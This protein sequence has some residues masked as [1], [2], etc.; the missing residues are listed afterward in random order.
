MKAVAGVKS[1]KAE[2]D[3]RTWWEVPEND[4][5]DGRTW[6]VLQ[7]GSPFSPYHYPACFAVRTDGGK[8]NQ[9]MRFGGARPGESQYRKM[10]LAYGKRTDDM[11]AYLLPGGQIFSQEGQ[12]LFPVAHDLLW[13]S[14]QLANSSIYIRH[15]NYVAGQHKYHNYLNL[16]CLPTG[17]LRSLGITAKRLFAE[18]VVLDACN[19]TSLGFVGCSALPEFAL[20]QAHDERHKI[21]KQRQSLFNQLRIDADNEVA[22]ALEARN[23]DGI[24]PVDYYHAYFGNKYS[25]CLAGMII[26]S[27]A[28][29][30]AFGRWNV[31]LSRHQ[32]AIG[33]NNSNA[34]VHQGGLPPGH[35]TKDTQQ[36]SESTPLRV[37]RSGILPDDLE[38]SDD[39]VHMVRNALEAVWKE[40]ADTIETDLCATLTVESIREY[41]RKTTNGGFWDDHVSRYS[42]SRRKAPIYWLLQSS[43]KNYALWLYYHRLDKDIL[44]KALVNYVEPKIRL[45]IGNLETLRRKKA[46]AGDSGKAAKGIAKDLEEQEEF[47]SELRDFEDKLRRAANLHLEPDLNDGVVLNIAPLH[48][49]VPWKEAGDYWDGLLAGKYEWSSIGK[50][51]RQKGL[52]K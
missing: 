5:G 35:R 9:L 7:N 10:G 44:F 49:L 37:S 6:E 34:S 29:G 2:A 18:L 17:H 26:A 32:Q 1:C 41:F 21:A 46:E 11:Y 4:I 28:I 20:E 25:D 19:E 43:N 8:W 16:I 51:L 3:F 52:V 12:A 36:G 30:C 45:E 23:E 13:Q 42:K 27:Y 47:L 48:E 31:K 14:L 15:A 39:V 22:S 38:H 50:Q 40:Q 24:R 33:K